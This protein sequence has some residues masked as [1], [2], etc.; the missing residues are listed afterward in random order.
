MTKHQINIEDFQS[1]LGD[2]PLI[3]YASSSKEQ[4]RLYAT[5]NGNYEVHCKGKVVWKGSQPFE[6]TRQY[7]K[8]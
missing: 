1:W 8:I 3:L 4:K 2:N 6:A 5:T 7:N